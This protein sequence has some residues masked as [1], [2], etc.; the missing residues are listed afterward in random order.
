MILVYAPVWATPRRWNGPVHLARFGWLGRELIYAVIRTALLTA[1]GFWPA[2]WAVRT[3]IHPVD[4]VG[5]AIF[6]LL[7][8]RDLLGAHIV[9]V[10]T[11]D[12]RYWTKPPPRRSV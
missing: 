5:A 9:D 6:P 4:P 12:P 7:V 11:V 3:R 1:A 8:D 2:L 10:P